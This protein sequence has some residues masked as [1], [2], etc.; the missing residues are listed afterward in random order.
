MGKVVSQ[1]VWVRFTGDELQRL[2][3]TA[4]SDYYP[5]GTLIQVHTKQ[6][7][8]R[9]EEV[10]FGVRLFRPGPLDAGPLYCP[11]CGEGTFPDEEAVDAHY[12]EVHAPIRCSECGR[13]DFVDEEAVIEHEEGCIG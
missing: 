13:D 9:I 8:D 5:R 7:D 12:Q 6:K 1:K 3:Q 11:D 2:L 10:T 4:A